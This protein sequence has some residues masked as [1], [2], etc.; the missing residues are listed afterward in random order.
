MKCLF[1]LI[2]M[3]LISFPNYL[4]SQTQ[5]SAGDVSGTWQLAGSP[6]LINGE[7]TIPNDSTLIIEPGVLVEF[8]G[9]YKLN[10][11]GRLLAVGTVTDTIVF[12][13]ND[14]IGFS[15]HN[16]SAGGWHGIRFSWTSPAN[17]S[18]KIRFC[19]LQYG[20]AIG[21]NWHDQQG[22]AIFVEDFSKLLI[23]NCLISNNCVVGDGVHN[24]EGGG[25]S[26]TKCNI[27][28]DNCIFIKNTALDTLGASGAIVVRADTTFTGFP[29]QVK[30]TNCQFIEN[31]ATRSGA[32]VKINNWGDDSLIINVIVDNCEFI[33]NA[34]DHG[35][36]LYIK[37]SSF[38][39]SNSIFI[40]NKAVRFAAGADF[41]PVS[42][43]TVSNCLFASN[44]AATGGGNWNSGGVS[45][46]GG[47]NVDFMNCTFANNSAT[48]GAGLTV[49][50]GG[51]ASTTNCIF[52]SNTNDQLALESWNN[53][54]G[55]LEVHYCDVQNGIDQV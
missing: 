50:N 21:T 24:N 49:G 46:W 52:W 36:G 3:L 18:S 7:V 30:I 29:Y 8:Q 20:K 43:G 2:V 10:V 15:N 35:T 22:G 47:A 1:I 5:V 9:H 12:T 44:I 32:G 53:I 6:Y 45:V 33:N 42:S 16:S 23:S 4:F 13:I 54:G 26:A 27:A 38:T 25:I 51:N 14:T 48:Y 55:T 37:N 28:I 40:G 19:K 41:Y 31:A 39:V 11:Q 34:S 17:D